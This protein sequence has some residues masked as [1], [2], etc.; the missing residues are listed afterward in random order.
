MSG[1]VR[2]GSG[3]FRSVGVVSGRLARYARTAGDGIEAARRCCGGHGY[4]VLSGLPGLVGDYNAQVP[5]KLL[6]TFRYPTTRLRYYV[7]QATYYVEPS[8]QVPYYNA[9]V[10]SYYTA[11]WRTTILLG[12][13][14]ILYY[15]LLH[16]TI[17]HYT[18]L[19]YTILP[20]ILWYR[21]TILLGELVIHPHQYL[22]VLRCT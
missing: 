22:Y 1:R 16:Y 10:P 13:V 7:E 3:R 8:A 4:S 9:Q 12:E 19:Y 17:L 21:P 5:N 20:T 6:A 11:E 14:V 18:I 15:F 2:V